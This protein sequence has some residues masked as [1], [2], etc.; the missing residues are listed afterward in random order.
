MTYRD[1]R[2]EFLVRLACE[3]PGV[4]PTAIIDF[5]RAILRAARTVQ[6]LAETEC[7]R[8]LTDREERRHVAAESR[9]RVS[10][11][12]LSSWS[13]DGREVTI[14]A[15]NSDPRGYCVKLRLP[16]GKGN[17]WGGDECGWGVPA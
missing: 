11:A 14:A 16:S 8:P 6:R 9:V 3:L 2:E 4:P 13:P 1:D 7:N 17:T 15:I 5:G 12:E 10:L